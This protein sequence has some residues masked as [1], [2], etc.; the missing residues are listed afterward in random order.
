MDRQP[1]VAFISLMDSAPWGGS[2]DLWAATARHAIG[3]GCSMAFSTYRWPLV[4]TQV[5]DLVGLGATWHPWTFP[6]REN[7]TRRWVRR[8]GRILPVLAKPIDRLIAPYRPLFEFRPDVVCINQGGTFDI[9]AHDRFRELLNESR[10]PYAVLCRSN[11]EGM[12]LSEDERA[13]ATDFFKKA[14]R[15]GFAARRNLQTAE[16]QLAETLA[17]AEVIQSPLNPRC[18]DAIPWAADPTARFACVARFYAAHKGQDVLLECLA[19]PRWKSRDWRLQLYGEGPD[20]PWLEKLSR[21]LGLGDR[22][23]FEGHTEDVAGIWRKNQML[24]LPS[25]EEGTP[26]CM[27]EAMLCGRPVMATD[28]GGV[29]DFVEEPTTGYLAEAPTVGS[30]GH[31]LERAWQT[32]DRWQSLGQSARSRALA[33]VEPAPHE[34]FFGTLRRLSGGT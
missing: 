25:R 1:R 28:V 29:S 8:C 5:S 34:T 2:E 22:V 15:I 13:N 18:Q 6:Q 11:R 30:V 10:R 32:R 16:R 17:N 9:L 27:K 23:T 21:R 4:P 7:D 14:G 20:R 12:P 31:A 19:E 3:A 24:L 26:Q 33:Q